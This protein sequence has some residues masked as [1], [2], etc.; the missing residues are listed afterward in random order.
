MFKIAR[1]P[2]DESVAVEVDETFVVDIQRRDGKLVIEVWP[3]IL[4]E[5]PV[6]TM[7]VFDS[8]LI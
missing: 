8:D 7:T 3:T 6:K 5:K 1:Y 4:G 2:V